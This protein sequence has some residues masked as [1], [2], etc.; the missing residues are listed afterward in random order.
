MENLMTKIQNKTA[1]VGIMGM[2]YVGLPLAMAFAKQFKVIG[3][4]VNVTTINTLKA[5]KSHIKDVPTERVKEVLCATFFPSDK[6]EDL[7]DC[8]AFIICVPTPLNTEHE[9]ELKYVRSATETIAKQLRKEQLVILESTTYPG[10]VSEV[11]KPILEKSGLKAGE[12][13]YLVHSPERIDP[14]N[15]SAVEDIPK[16]VGG[17]TQKCTDCGVLLYSYALKHIVPVSNAKTAEAVKIMENTYRCINIAL[18]NELSIVFSQM[19]IDTWEVVEAASTKP[20]GFSAFTPGPGIGGHC[21]PLD[22]YYLSYQAQKFGASTR[23]ITLAGEIN[24]YMKVYTISLARNA[25]KTFGKSMQDSRI[26]IF[27]LSYKKNINDARESPAEYIIHYLRSEGAKII[28]HDP[29]ISEFKVGSEILT[30]EKSLE[31][32]LSLADC[33]IFLVDHDEYTTLSQEKIIENMKIPIVIDCKNIFKENDKLIYS[34][35]GKSL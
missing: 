32:A 14:G 18:I 31:K 4:D 12:D 1:V 34:G 24:Q 2:G 6:E 11:M 7:A 13:F 30:C 33:A 21:I 15:T 8:D 27:G 5:G 19:G 9:P 28:L 20:Y 26:A 29:G 22:P 23:F 10:T 35:I 17:L 3:Y 16:I 25:L